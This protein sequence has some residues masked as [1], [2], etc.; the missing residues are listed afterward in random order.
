MIEKTGSR[1]DIPVAIVEE[2]DTRHAMVVMSM[3]IVSQLGFLRLSIST[4]RPAAG[5]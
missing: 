4:Q 2:D 1:R 3:D 5:E